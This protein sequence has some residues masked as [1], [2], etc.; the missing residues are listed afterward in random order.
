MIGAFIA[1]RKEVVEVLYSGFT[2]YQINKFI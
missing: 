1:C 2:T